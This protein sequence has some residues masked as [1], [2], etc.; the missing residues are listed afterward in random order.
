MAAA[1]RRRDVGAEPGIPAS[2]SSHICAQRG[3]SG[4]G[5]VSP[6]LLALAVNGSHSAILVIDDDAQIQFINVGFTGLLGYEFGDLHGRRVGQM[7]IGKHTDPQ[8]FD[9]IG[10]LAASPNGGRSE[11]LLYDKHGRPL[12]ISAAI[13]PV[14][15]AD[16]RRTHVVCALTDMTM[17]KMREVLQH[18]VL[19]AMAHGLPLR[20]VLVLLCREVERVAPE[21][22]AFVMGVDGENRLRS[23][24]GPSLSP[25]FRQMIDGLPA[26]VDAEA[27][28]HGALSRQS[29][30]V[31][32]ITADSRWADLRETAIEENLAACWLNPIMAADGRV[33]GQ[34]AFYYREP[35]APDAFHQGLAD[36]SMHLC[37]LALSGEETE[38][39]MHRLAFYDT[40]TGLQ[41]GAMLRAVTQRMLKDSQRADAPL[42]LM[43]IDLDRFKRVNETRGL[44]A[45][46]DLLRE[47][48]RRLVAQVRGIDLVARLG[49]DEFVVVLPNC[50]APQA[51][52]AA[53]RL[54]NTLGQRLDLDGLTLSPQ[55]S[56]GIAMFPDDGGDVGALLQ[57][58]D[59]AMM[60]AKA[61]GRGS[62]CFF[63]ADMNS[64][65]RERM[66]LEI[67]LREA[68]LN[69]GLRLNYQP[70]VRSALPSGLHGVEALLRWRHP[71]QG[72]ISPMCFIPLAEE[73]GLIDAVS[74]WVLDEACRQMVEWR[75]QG[76]SVPRVA[77]NLSARNFR[78]PM[79]P[80]QISRALRL[81]GLEPHEL[82]LEMTESVMLDDS[83]EVLATVAAVHALGVQLSLDD[84][85]TGYSSLSYLHRLPIG[86]LKLDKSFINDLGESAAAQALVNTVLRIGESLGVLVV[87]EGVERE[88]QRA[89]LAGGGCPVLQ[90]YLLARPLPPD[91]LAAWLLAQTA[92]ALV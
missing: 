19:E 76:V 4:G 35:R 7:L 49:G 75:R 59:T 60:Q 79:L 85:G 64:N 72:E 15:A 74:L 69:G 65:A 8:E 70:Q 92:S 42:A 30:V 12:W 25:R 66:A 61:N 33:L 71:Q 89:F 22:V 29:L 68:L 91:E 56:I 81:H 50:S 43:F 41:N 17:T 82:T 21:V 53:E 51:A 84:F 16:G 58:A 28:V 20:D 10:A 77:I 87:A 83:A 73:C 18:K 63:R 23:L 24:A 3:A 47:I 9:R 90:G 46:D 52:V 13:T 14:F 2:S 48:A 5:T 86:E 37:T 88:G 32:D 55:A 45:G 34:F 11:I 54:L 40:L 38:A 57:H 39:R 78:N 26:G 44:S 67:D 27:S 62:F 6:D 1:R 80:S 31:T 36:V